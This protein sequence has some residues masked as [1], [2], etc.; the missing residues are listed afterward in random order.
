MPENVKVAVI[1]SKLKED[2]FWTVPLVE[3][4]LDTMFP[5]IHLKANWSFVGLAA[6]ITVNVQPHRY[7]V[8]HS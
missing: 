8:A 4:I 5:L 1:R 6:C 2:V 7:I 3:Y